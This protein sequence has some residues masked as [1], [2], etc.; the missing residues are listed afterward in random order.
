MQLRLTPDQ[1]EA[2]KAL[3]AAVEEVK[4]D[5]EVEDDAAKKEALQVE[6]KDRESKLDGLMEQFEVRPCELARSCRVDVVFRGHRSK[7]W[8]AETGGGASQERRNWSQAIRETPPSRGSSACSRRIRWR[9]S[10]RLR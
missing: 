1:I 2:K 4:Q 5:L 6:L 7:T 10:R 3:E 9:P 8:S